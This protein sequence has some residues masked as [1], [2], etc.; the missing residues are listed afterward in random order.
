MTDRVDLPW[1]GLLCGCRKVKEFVPK[2]CL[3]RFH[4]ETFPSLRGCAGLGETEP[5]FGLPV[6]DLGSDMIS[7]KQST[8]VRDKYSHAK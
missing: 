2:V 4:N 7:K 6:E 3:A 8:Q 1:V 5:G